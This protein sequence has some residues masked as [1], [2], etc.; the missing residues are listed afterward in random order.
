MDKDPILSASAVNHGKP[1]PHGRYWLHL[2]SR[3]DFDHLPNLV[4]AAAEA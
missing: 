3:V 1:S 2:R 4:F